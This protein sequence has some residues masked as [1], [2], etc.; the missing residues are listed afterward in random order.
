MFLG[1]KSAT[2]SFRP[3]KNLPRNRGIPSLHGKGITLTILSFVIFHLAELAGETGGR[4]QVRTLR[5]FW[6]RASRKV[7]H[8]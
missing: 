7:L 4:Q 8:T 3:N 5:R 2:W 1:D 6:L